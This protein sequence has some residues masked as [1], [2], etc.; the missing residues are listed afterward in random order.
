MFGGKDDNVT[1]EIPIPR[2]CTDYHD[3]S[4]HSKGLCAQSLLAVEISYSNP[5]LQA[6]LLAASAG[7][8]Q[9]L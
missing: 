1:P 7:N 6:Q 8:T 2:Q 3:A 4:K 5:L 9:E